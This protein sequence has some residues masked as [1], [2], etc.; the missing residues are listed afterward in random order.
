MAFDASKAL[1][2]LLSQTPGDFSTTGEIWEF[3]LEIYTTAM[4]ISCELGQMY[5]PFEICKPFAISS[6]LG[7]IGSRYAL[8]KSGEEQ[9]SR[10]QSNR[11]PIF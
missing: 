2:W 11:R 10:P 3:H 8:L 6:D 7:R 9:I 4:E 5:S 1:H